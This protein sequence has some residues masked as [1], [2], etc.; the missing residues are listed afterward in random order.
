MAH[1]TGVFRLGRDAEVRYTQ[2]GDAVCALSFAYSYGKKGADGKK[3]T[4]WI[5]ASLW[6]KRAETLASYLLKGVMI[7]ACMSDLHIEEFEGKNGHGVKIAARIDDLEFVGG[8][9]SEQSQQPRQQPQRQAPK[10]RQQ[11]PEVDFDDDLPF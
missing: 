6:G 2:N 8:N 1:M 7:Y 5:E 3:P 4:Q 11:P 10:P 9:S